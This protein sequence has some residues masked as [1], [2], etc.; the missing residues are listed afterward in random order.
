MAE[1]VF[2]DVTMSEPFELRLWKGPFERYVA[3][4]VRKEG[5]LELPTWRPHIPPAGPDA[6]LTLARGRWVYAF[7]VAANEQHNPLGGEGHVFQLGIS[8]VFELFVAGDGTITILFDAARELSQRPLPGPLEDTG[9]GG[10]KLL[11]LPTRIKLHKL[12][13]N[14]QWCF[15]GSPERLSGAAVRSLC[16]R[17]AFRLIPVRLAAPSAPPRSG[18]DAGTVLYRLPPVLVAGVLDLA[19]VGP[20]LNAEYRRRRTSLLVYTNPNAAADD[21]DRAA[22]VD[23]EKKRLLAEI[24]KGVLAGGDP[25]EI[26]GHLTPVARG[27][28]TTE[29]EAWPEEQ[30]QAV[31][32]LVEASE[33]AAADV[34]RWLEEPLWVDVLE[35]TLRAA[36]AYEPWL[37]IWARSIDQLCDS[38]AGRS[39]LGRHL[40]DPKHPAH[41][42]ALPAE[43]VP[44]E[45]F[46]ALQ[47]S[48]PAV[49]ALWIEY[50]KAHVALRRPLADVAKG[51]ERL[52]NQPLV[53]VRELPSG[54]RTV[55]TSRGYITVQFTAHQLEVASPAVWA[56]WGAAAERQLPKV[57]VLGEVVNLLL[58]LDALRKAEPR[59]LSGAKQLLTAASSAA[60]TYAAFMA[61]RKAE[62]SLSHAA[63]E[64]L[65]RRIKVA[66]GVAAAID[67]VCSAI[68]AHEMAGRD[69]YDAM[70]G[71]V[72]VGLGSALVAAGCLV[73]VASIAP[74][75]TVVGLPLAA[76]LELAGAILVGI[77]TVVVVLQSDSDLQL[78]A[79]HCAFGPKHGDGDAA[80]PWT[81]GPF[82][83]WKGDLARQTRI[84]CALIS[85]FRLASVD[86]QTFRVVYGF[87]RPESRLLLRIHVEYNLATLDTTVE[88]HFDGKVL[89]HRSGDRAKLVPTF[90]NHEGRRALTLKV[91]P[92]RSAPPGGTFQT[93]K[94]TASAQLLLGGPD[95]VIPASKKWVTLT[96]A[97][98]DGPNQWAHGAAESKNF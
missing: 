94:A 12:D 32:A 25:A 2:G 90:G 49:V 13:A 93:H 89:V 34:A 29:A 60:T 3:R 97:G 85:G 73:A 20:S 19:T 69:D 28:S 51:L 39:L 83:A 59:S 65:E 9:A 63:A 57:L 70:I 67:V 23:R 81:L 75:A 55:L 1:P 47:K 42:W 50:S 26:R 18:R 80:L 38:V 46:A 79:T 27:S 82:R 6:A 48:V 5:A 7:A 31:R 11:R 77:G 96:W 10:G 44:Q 66:S 91:D 87:T 71:H 92:P 36:A 88:V 72:A 95:E 52:S 45:V 76:A 30:D 17:T 21:A 54:P 74:G 62:G 78:F 53:L 22:C 37:D 64:V 24:L 68:E 56:R 86:W 14:L 58:A 43:T 84:L 33:G 98:M 41:S 15:V 35:P 4:P 40:L 8:W 16:S 61:L